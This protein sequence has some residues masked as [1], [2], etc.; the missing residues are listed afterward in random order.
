M[1]PAFILRSFWL[2][3][4]QEIA[5]ILEYGGG[6]ASRESNILQKNSPKTH[7]LV[8]RLITESV[9]QNSFIIARDIRM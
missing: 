5:P 6:V 8:N 2:P 4:L 1:F 7:I 9:A 3:F